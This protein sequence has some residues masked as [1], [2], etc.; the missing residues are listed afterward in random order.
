MDDPFTG[1]FSHLNMDCWTIPHFFGMIFS[2]LPIQMEFPSHGA[3][4]RRV[5]QLHPLALS[6]TNCADRGVTFFSL[7]PLLL[8]A[9]TSL[10]TDVAGI[11]VAS[12]ISFPYL[13]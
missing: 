8:V 7:P 3:D 4:D 12:F 11:V 6:W 5:P 10:M 9:Q 2:N 13:D 1:C